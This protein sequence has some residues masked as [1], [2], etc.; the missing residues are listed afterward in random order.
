MTLN[1]NGSFT[2]KHDGSETTR[3]SFTY[4]VNDGKA[5]SNTATV[6]ITVTPVNDPPVAKNDGYLATNGKTLIVGV[7]AGVLVNDTDAEGQAL[8]AVLVSKPSNGTLTLNP[9]G[10]FLYNHDGGTTTSDSFTYRAGDGAANSNTATVT[11]KVFLTL[12]QQAT[13]AASD[14]GDGDDFGISVAI[15]KDTLVVGAGGEDPKDVINAG[16]AYVFT[17]TGTV[18]SQQAKLIAGDAAAGD[19]FGISVAISGNTAVVGAWL[20]DGVGADSGSAYVFARN[21]TV[22]TQQAKLTA[23][24]TAGGDQFGKGITHRFSRN[25]QRPP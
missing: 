16:A 13:L 4:K 2:Y 18:W 23:G 14:A 24:D 20:D 9:N 17:R 19:R 6:T 3:D 22:W 25:P 21:G 11:I 12:L 15:D 10:S 7:S 5:D 1:S 8:T